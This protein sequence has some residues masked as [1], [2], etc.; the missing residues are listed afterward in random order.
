MQH[1]LMPPTFPQEAFQK[2][3]QSASKFFPRFMSDEYLDDPLQK[4]QHFDLAWV[5]VRYRYRACSEYNEA[6]KTLFVNAKAND[7]WREWGDDEEINYKLEQNVYQF[8]MSGLSVFDS[9]GFCL[10]FIG[11]GVSSAHFPIVEKKT[12]WSITLDTTREA[13]TTAFPQE[14]ITNYLIELSKDKGFKNIKDIRNILS[15]RVIAR[16]HVREY[17]STHSDGTYT[18]TREEVLYVPDS[19]AALP[20]DEELIQRNFNEIT[21]LLTTLISASLEFVVAH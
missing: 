2:F 16:R 21:R 9:L 5:A 4:R 6:F 15:H 8:F 18:H 14:S 13:F 1:I 19:K 20:F 12:P 17:G 10:Y 7:L 11:S 3:A